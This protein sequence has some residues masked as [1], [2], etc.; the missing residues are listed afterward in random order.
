MGRTKTIDRDRILDVAEKITVEQGPTG[1]T[2][3]AVAEAMGITNG[4]VQYSFRSKEALIAAIF[5]RWRADYD[6]RAANVEVAPDDDPHPVRTHLALSARY[7]ERS[8]GRGA[9]MLMS[10]LQSPPH[11]ALIRDW[12]R[13]R[14]PDPS[15]GAEEDRRLRLAFL[16]MEGAFLMRLFGLLDMTDGEWDSVVADVGSLARG[17]PVADTA[18]TVAKFRAA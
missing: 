15:T 3:A 4:G 16:A 17:M 12:Y 18:G 10:V 13:E 1:L 5:E 11:I 2:I 6:R 9:S 8:R 7:D 14:L